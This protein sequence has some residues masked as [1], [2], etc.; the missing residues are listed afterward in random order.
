[1]TET[2]KS[3]RKFRATKEWKEFSKVIKAEQKIDPLT[4][5]KLV[6]GCS[7]HH[8]DLHEE[9]YTELKKEK[10]IVCNNFSHKCI[11]FFFT[12]YKRDKEVLKRLEKI[13]QEMEKY[14]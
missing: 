3:K 4:L 8:L 14:L 11:H 12:I 7:C 1:M 6:K 13:M 2:Q 10:F 9:N 5:N